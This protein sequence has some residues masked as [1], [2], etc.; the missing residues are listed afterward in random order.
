MGR[1]SS[2]NPRA[3]SADDQ[4]VKRRLVIMVTVGI[5]AI[6]GM[7]AFAALRTPQATSA[8]QGSTSH[9]SKAAIRDEEAQIALEEVVDDAEVQAGGYKSATSFI[10]VSVAG[11]E[12]DA[13]KQSP[14][15]LSA[16]MPRG[17]KVS[18]N[19][20]ADSSTCQEIEASSQ[21]N[22]DG[23]CW[24]V[25]SITPLQP[26]SP[27]RISYGWT[28]NTGRCASGTSGDPVKP[29]SGWTGNLPQPS[30]CGGSSATYP[31][32]SLCKDDR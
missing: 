2:V 24:F 13:A 17:A 4:Y 1:S 11:L 20:C 18:V 32:A 10:H 30:D 27:F 8:E 19:L 21:G 23:F 25:R 9:L 3:T 29:R 31:P 22:Q 14:G 28:P 6:A 5:A 12:Q 15:W 7:L 26:G 16:L